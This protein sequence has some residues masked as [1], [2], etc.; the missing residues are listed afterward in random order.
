[1]IFKITN[2]GLSTSTSISQSQ[3]KSASKYWL[4]ITHTWTA[5]KIKR[6]EAQEWDD[7]TA[8]KQMLKNALPRQ[9]NKNEPHTLMGKWANNANKHIRSDM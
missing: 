3:R 2:I 4:Q 6:A 8:E 7:R 9:L 1:M 5:I